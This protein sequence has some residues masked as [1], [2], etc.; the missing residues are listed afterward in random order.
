VTIQ[1]AGDAGPHQTGAVPELLTAARCETGDYEIPEVS[2]L[3][4]DSGPNF[5]LR[6]QQGARLG[7]FAG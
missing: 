4:A 5:V 1:A 3:A 7:L 2:G 6:V